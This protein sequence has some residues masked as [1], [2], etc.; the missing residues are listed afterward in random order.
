MPLSRW[1]A[2]H[3]GCQAAV[4]TVKADLTQEIERLRVE[5]EQLR[6]ERDEL[7]RHKD[8]DGCTRY[9][10]RWKDAFG[11]EGALCQCGEWIFAVHAADCRPATEAERA[12]PKSTRP[13]RR[14]NEP[15]GFDPDD[16]P[17]V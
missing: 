8:G 17:L 1:Q 3:A 12:N 2:R 7:L 13:I 9:G 5:N 15:I 10:H 14:E 6:M 4:D 11:P 16:Y